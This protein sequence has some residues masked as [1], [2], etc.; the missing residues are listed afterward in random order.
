MNHTNTSQGRNGRDE[1]KIRFEFWHHIV[2][3]R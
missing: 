1:S 2:E 3:V